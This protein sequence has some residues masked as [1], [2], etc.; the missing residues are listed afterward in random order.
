MFLHMEGLLSQNKYGVSTLNSDDFCLLV[1]PGVSCRTVWVYRDPPAS[2]SCELG[3]KALLQ[4]ATMTSSFGPITSQGLSS[5]VWPAATKTRDTGLTVPECPS[6]LMLWDS[7]LEW[8]WL[9][10]DGGSG[11][12]GYE[13]EFCLQPLHP[14][15]NSLTSP[16]VAQMPW[17]SDFLVCRKT[18]E[19][20]R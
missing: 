5:C 10:A 17:T 12:R 18:G 2:D 4:S 20:C 11:L 6:V 8:G 14:W 7:I 1:C 19:I 16:L 15:F 3:S 9:F 13:H